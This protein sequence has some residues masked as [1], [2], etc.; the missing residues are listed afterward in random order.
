MVRGGRT[1]RWRE[2]G[3]K[4]MERGVRRIR[5]IEGRGRYDGERGE[6]DTMEIGVVAL[7]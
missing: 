4:K 7:V 2:G 1:I 5:W 3:E 6:D